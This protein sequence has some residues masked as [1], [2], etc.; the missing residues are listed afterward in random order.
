[1]GRRVTVRDVAAAAGVSVS[2]ASRVL[3]QNPSVDPEMARKVLKASLELGYSANVFARALRTKRTDTVGMVVPSISNTYFVAVVEAVEQVLAERGRSLILCDARE[4][5]ETEAQR[6]EVLV[7]RMVDG[8]IVV[9]VTTYESV[10][11]IEAAAGQVPVVLF[12]RWADSAGTDFVGADNQ[13]GVRQ[14]IKH[15]RKLGARS[16]VYVGAEPRTSTAYERLKAFRELVT[17]GADVPG[18]SLLGTFTAEWGERAARELLARGPLPD[19][20]VCGA[21]V[22][23]F[24]LLSTLRNSGVAIPGDVRVA[25]FDGSVLSQ[26]TVPRLTSVRQ[27]IDAMASEAVRLLDARAEQRDRPASKSIFAPTLLVGPST[28][29]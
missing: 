25:S 13:E 21:D 15:L 26:L 27:P 4:S 8:L 29:G 24:A 14:S 22:I 2:T 1:M 11:A 9:P 28:S 18:T 3:S 6:I 5:T 10:P 17:D 7:Q 19:A 12:D 23:A 16:I 20:V